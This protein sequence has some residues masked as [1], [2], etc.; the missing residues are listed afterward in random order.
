MTTMTTDQAPQSDSARLARMRRE[1][2]AVHPDVVAA[3]RA[4][5]E[6]LQP[7]QTR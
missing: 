5:D 6:R 1:C 4:D 3:R 2:S 7:Q